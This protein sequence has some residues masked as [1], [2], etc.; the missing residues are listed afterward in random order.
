MTSRRL[1]IAVA[2]SVAI[3]VA[4][5]LLFRMSLEKAVL[6]APV[7]LVTA[8]LT[9]AV[10]LLWARV[11]LESLRRQRRPGLIVAGG[12]AIL[13]LLVALSFFV[14]LPSTH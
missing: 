7:I 8:G 2:T 3:L 11:A 4:A 6:L 14:D 10:F 5:A 9:I 12:I 13:G 1:S